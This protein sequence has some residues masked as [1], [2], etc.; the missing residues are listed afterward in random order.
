MDFEKGLPRSNKGH[1]AIWVIMD[2]LTKSSLFLPIKMGN[3]VEK[4]AQL[5]IKEVVRL[6]GVPVAIVSNRYPRFT[7]RLWPSIQRALGTRLNLSTT[8]HPKTNGQSERTIQILE[9]LLRSCILE[10]R[11]Q[12]EDHLPLIVSHV[13]SQCP[14]AIFILSFVLWE[15]SP[16][17]PLRVT[18]K[19]ECIGRC[20]RF[21]GKVLVV[22]REGFNTPSAPY[23]R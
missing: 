2:R 3:S 8:F 6:H 7:S 17:I 19:P 9:Y 16:S 14:L 12:W 20:Q 23:L 13:P 15:S 21:E 1:D 10:F 5:Y 4:L 18:R 22:A 11:G